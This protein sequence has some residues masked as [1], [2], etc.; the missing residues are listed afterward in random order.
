MKRLLLFVHYD[1][2]GK[3]DDH[4]LYLLNALR[5]FCTHSVVIANSPLNDTDME[6]LSPVADRVIRREN[7]GFDFG[8]WGEVLPEYQEALAKEF[9]TLLLVNGSCFG[10][11]FPLHEMFDKMVETPCDFWG[12]TE[13]TAANG[14]PAHLQSYF[15]EIRNPILHSEAFYRFFREVGAK[16]TDFDAAVRH[17]EIGFS[18]AM[19][20][21][22]FHYRS[23]V[24]V[25]DTQTAPNVGIQEA[26]SRNCAD[27]LIRRYRLPLLKIKAFGQ[28]AGCSVFRAGSIFRALQES[29][30]TYPEKL[31]YPYLRRTAPLSWQKNLP[32]TLLTADRTGEPMQDLSIKTGVMFHCFRPESA[33]KI[34]PYLANIPADFDLLVTSPFQETEQEVRKLASS[35]QHC[36]KIS[37][38]HTENRG[39]DIAPWLCG[40][41]AEQ[42][43]SYDVIL[44]LHVKSSPQMPEA[45]TAD[46]QNYLYD[47]L[48]GS[49]ALIGEVLRAFAAEPE[50]GTV[51][52]PYP[53]IVT[54]QCPQAYAGHPDD[55]MAGQAILKELQLNPPQETG[56]PVFSPGTMFWY[57]PE[58]IRNLLEK[59]W[60]P[61]DFPAEP[62]PWRGTAAHAMERIIPYIMQA[63]GFYFRHCLHTDRLEEAF[64][65]Y[66]NRVIYFTPTL[67]QAFKTV[68]TA[69]GTSCCYRLHR[70]F[71]HKGL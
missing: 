46:W 6:R 43:L 53:P 58:A 28:A 70:F 12:V 63:N 68:L 21:A 34:I 45:F 30:S 13:H 8:A 14:V 64:R 16:C 71:R 39:R 33:E 61:E 60:T 18:Q 40:F 38:S 27:D 42:H 22:G 24:E 32:D 11:L 23:Y 59:N 51:F 31:I 17:G 55:A 4:V 47:N 9:D 57:R 1:R 44:K 35:L 56:L 65:T 7:R 49:P 48:A 36:R 3:L 37:F 25:K 5:P 50:L 41:P 67:K 52:P 26:F 29:G 62:L 69:L 54:L 15:M 10:P 2:D 19:K 66:E 20:T